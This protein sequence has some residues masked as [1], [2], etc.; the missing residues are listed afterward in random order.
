ME[1]EQ[2]VRENGFK[3]AVQFA[4][5][6]ARSTSN[7]PVE[8]LED[9]I[10]FGEGL[11]K[12][13]ISLDDAIEVEQALKA[14]RT[15]VL[16]RKNIEGAPMTFEVAATGETSNG[17]QSVVL[18][19][20]ELGELRVGQRALVTITYDPTNYEEENDS[21]DVPT[22]PEQDQSAGDGGAGQESPE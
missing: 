2:Q 16:Y 3:A 22:S 5:A 8:V 17:K 21:A 13:G 4:F 10:A 19:G 15:L 6:A 7:V 18:N 11:V 20:T 14:L 1:R 9:A 12:P